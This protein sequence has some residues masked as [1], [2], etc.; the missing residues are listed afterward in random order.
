LY[1]D[2]D[3]LYANGAREGHLLPAVVHDSSIQELTLDLHGMSAAV[4]H[5]A[6]RVSIQQEMSRL[7][8]SIKSTNDITWSKD[9]IIIT[10]RGLRSGQKFKPVLR[11]EVQRMLTEEF[12]PPLGSSTLP[13][14][15]GALTVQSEDVLAWLTHQQQQKGERLLMV[16]NALRGISSG[17]R[18]KQAIMSNG[19]RLQKALRRTLQEKQERGNTGS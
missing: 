15:L 3:H 14:N 2:A 19:S 9:I 13:G 10:G 4:A 12:F 5:A 1:D 11:P 6:V 8:S 18:L 17:A 7:Q 16:A